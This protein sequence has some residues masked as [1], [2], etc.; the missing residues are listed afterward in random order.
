MPGAGGNDGGP[1]QLHSHQGQVVGPVGGI[2]L[3][4]AASVDLQTGQI[5]VGVTRAEIQ[6]RVADY[7]APGRAADGNHIVAVTGLDGQAAERKLTNGG[8][9][10]RVVAVAQVEVSRPGE[11]EWADRGDRDIVVASLHHRLDGRHVVE[12][13]AAGDDGANPHDGDVRARLRELDDIRVVVAGEGE[14]AAG[15]RGVDEPGW[16]VA[17]LT[18]GQV[19][20]DGRRTAGR[21][22]RHG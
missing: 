20:A 9:A 10:E 12:R 22:S 15:E 13:G 16:C 6:R 4:P 2:E 3:E 21:G 8:E 19:K 1:R 17:G 7:L 18:L 5:D 11:R 14:D